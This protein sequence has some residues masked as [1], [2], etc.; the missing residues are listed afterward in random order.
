MNVAY[1]EF[2]KELMKKKDNSVVYFCD[3]SGNAQ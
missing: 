1:T 2:K 3:E